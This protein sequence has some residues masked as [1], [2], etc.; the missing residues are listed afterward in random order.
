MRESNIC[1]I[2]LM[3]SLSQTFHVPWTC[4]DSCKRFGNWP[5]ANS[6]LIITATP[7]TSTPSLSPPTALFVLQAE[8]TAQQCSGTSTIQNIS[9]LLK[10]KTRFTHCV[11]HLLDT[12]FVLPRVVVSWFGIWRV[13]VLS[14]SWNRSRDRERR[15]ITVSVWLGVRMDKL[16]LVDILITVR[17]LF[18][19]W[20]Q[21]DFVFRYLRLPGLA[22]FLVCL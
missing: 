18:P 21:A 5:N 16:C 4:A 1:V 10:L 14:K 3:T 19:L 6:A 9:T 12:G 13:R 22:E 11:S 7:D 15:M 17:S 2:Y 20:T 8:K